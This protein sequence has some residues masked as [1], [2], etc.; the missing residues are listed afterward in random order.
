MLLGLVSVNMGTM[1]RPDGLVAAARAAEAA[2]F[3]SV[4]A[5]E[6]IVLPDP[7]VPPSPMSPQD[8]AL[9]SLLATGGRRHI[10]G[11]ARIAPVQSVAERDGVHRTGRCS[12]W[13]RE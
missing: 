8:P 5:G 9:D 12:T 2:G 4:W 10:G 3:D 1:S 6:H 13:I 7:Q 11:G